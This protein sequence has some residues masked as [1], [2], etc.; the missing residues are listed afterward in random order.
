M[1]LGF[2][3]GRL[4]LILPFVCMFLGIVWLG[5]L[6]AALPEA[7]WPVILLALFLGLILSRSKRHYV[8]AVISGISSP[9]L[10]IMLLAWFLAG[11][12][13]K[14]LIATGLVEGLIWLAETAQLPA[15][16]FPLVTFFIAA[17]LSLSNGTSIGTL[18]AAT[19][20]LFPAGYSMG[21]D[22]LLLIGALIGGAYVGDNLAPVSDTTIVSAYSQGTEVTRVVGSRLR[23]AAA[24]GVFTIVLYLILILIGPSG[25]AATGNS[26]GSPKGLLMLLIPALL[27]V[28]MLKGNHLV[29]ALFYSLATGIS[30]ALLVGQIA[31]SD[32]LSIDPTQF[33]AGGIVIEGINSMMGIAV[34]S[35]LLMGLVGVLEHGGFIEWMMERAERLAT[36]PTRA[37]LSIVFLT[38]LTNT[39]TTSGTPSMVIL[40]P[41]VRRLGHHFRL[42]PWRRANLLDACSTSI[43]GFL[44]FS[45]SVLIPFSLVADQVARSGT[46]PFSPVYL[47]PYVFYC[48]ALMLVMIFAAASGWGRD[49][50]SEE[51]YQAELRELR[52]GNPD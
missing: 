10:A 36:T 12:F 30:L 38:L 33:A 18:L 9:M 17:V 46:S 43:I 40:G 41:F 25:G 1:K 22:P 2:F 3:G 16:W 20:V 52:H 34:F 31:P 32:L 48:W 29:A 7:F 23:Y 44:P 14:L 4:G 47:V 39:L 49:F 27:V 15:G 26:T 51:E 35:I 8:D 6:G 19:P 50:M 13:G 24:A 37:E 11:I 42:T 21:A 45:I 5:I 28:L